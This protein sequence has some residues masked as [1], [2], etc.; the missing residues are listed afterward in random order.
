MI[1]HRSARTSFPPSK[2]G[3]VTARR[4]TIEKRGKEAEN[5]RHLNAIVASQKRKY[6]LLTAGAMGGEDIQGA[7]MDEPD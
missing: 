6:P 1:Q 5:L 3:R 2:V 7:E 4:N